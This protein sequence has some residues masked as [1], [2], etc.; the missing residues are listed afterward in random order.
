MKE[1]F[2]MGEEDIETLAYKVVHMLSSIET[3][4]AKVLLL[5]GDLG[6]G[7]TTFTKELA[8]TLGINKEKVNSPTFIL[9]KEYKADHSFFKKLIHVDAYRFATQGEAKV[10]KLEDDLEGESTIIAIE[11]PSK[12]KYLKP[13]V[14]LFF[15]ILDDTTREVKIVYEEQRL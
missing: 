3:S 5:D 15:T 10:L 13:D 9:K 1:I 6:A 7:K 11:W 4:K 14:H 2:T 8:A 12:M